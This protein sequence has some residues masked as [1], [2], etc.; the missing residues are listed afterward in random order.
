MTILLTLTVSLE[1]LAICRFTPDTLIPI[2]A[3]ASPFF[4][5]T[6]TTEELSVVCS[7][8]LIPDEISC[9]SDW[10]SLRI[11]GTLDFSWTGILVA[12]AEPLAANGISIFAISTYDTD[13]ILVQSDQL[14]TAIQVL[15]Q[16]GHTIE[17]A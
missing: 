5:I 9:Q 15:Q 10:C 1:R 2:W 6:R 12:V 7:S 14:S 13:Y 3:T 17:P 4:A 16:Y 8:A 11:V